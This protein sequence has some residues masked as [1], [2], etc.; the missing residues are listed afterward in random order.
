MPARTKGKASINV[1]IRQVRTGK[2]FLFILKM[3]I[4]M[5]NAIPVEVNMIPPVF[6]HF[7]AMI[8]IASRTNDGIRCIRKA[9]V[10]CQNVRSE[11]KESKAK[12]LTK[13]IAK[14]PIILAVQ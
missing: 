11:E 8:S 1:N 14:M 9:K 2:W 12:K 3:K 7:H 6:S 10:F 5:P 4:N 13:R